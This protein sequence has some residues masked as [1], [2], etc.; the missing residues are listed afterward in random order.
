VRG[1][2]R[3]RLKRVAIRTNVNDGFNEFNRPGTLRNRDLYGP[4]ATDPQALNSLHFEITELAE[5]AIRRRARLGVA[6]RFGSSRTPRR[7]KRLFL[8]L[9]DENA[10][11][12][13]R[14]RRPGKKSDH[15]GRK[16]S[17]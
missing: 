16:V 5:V 10:I 7:D 14:V 4:E 9:S 1:L 15:E 11:S 13:T 6:S 8:L 3:A 17:L 2:A 12:G